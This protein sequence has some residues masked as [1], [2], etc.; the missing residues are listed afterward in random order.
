VLE[1][2]DRDHFADCLPGL[3]AVSLGAMAEATG[4][5]EGYCSFIRRGLRM[6]HRR[7]WSVVTIMA[8]K[9]GQTNATEG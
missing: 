4:L 7:H 2:R 1:R 9:V 8:K 5:S 3:Q 6:P